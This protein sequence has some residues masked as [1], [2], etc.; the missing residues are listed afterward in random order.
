MTEKRK[1]Y[2]NP[3]EKI[4]EGRSTALLFKDSVPKSTI[5]KDMKKLGSMDHKQASLA[6]DTVMAALQLQ[7]E[8]GETIRLP[9]IG[10]IYV[11]RLPERPGLVSDPN[12]RKSRPGYFGVRVCY[13]KI[14]G[15]L[16]AK[17]KIGFR[18]LPE[19][20]QHLKEAPK[21]LAGISADHE[22]I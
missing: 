16:P 4:F 1:R 7:V 20:Q 2:T 13:D 10:Y 3:K 19:L 12:G 17:W 18:A 21:Y 11:D 22:L 5:L 8:A 14:P 9:G 15:I 6:Y